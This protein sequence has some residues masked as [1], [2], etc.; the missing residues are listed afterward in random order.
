MP[1]RKRVN[2]YVWDLEAQDSQM[3]VGA[4]LS[5]FL[6]TAAIFS[7]LCVALHYVAMLGFAF[8]VSYVCITT[9]SIP[10]RSPPSPRQQ[11]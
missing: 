5:S 9:P 2:K 10:G 11:W 4:L 7:L 1:T 3:R 6:Y 8:A